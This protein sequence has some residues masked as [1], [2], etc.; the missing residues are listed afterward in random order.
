MNQ[1]NM[2]ARAGR[3]VLFVLIAAAALAAGLG[4]GGPSIASDYP[5][6][7][8]R[9]VVPF[10][11]GGPVDTLARMVGQKLSERWSHQV[12]VENIA[13]ANGIIGS[14]AVAKSAPDGHT[15]LLVPVGH[16]MNA[17][18]Y[19]RLPF[20][21]LNDFTAVVNVAAA[22][23]VLVMHPSVPIKT[24]AELVAYAKANPAKLTYA[25]AGVGS[26]NHLAGA[27][28]QSLAG[29]NIVHVPYKGSAPATNDLLGGHVSMIFNNMV[30]SIPY[31]ERGQL[32]G[33]AVT[34]PRR[35]PALP[36]LPT[37]AESG[38]AGFE[39]TGWYGIFGPARM[40]AEIVRKINAEVNQVINAADVRERM[41]TQG[42]DP[43]GG[44]AESF[45]AFVKAE[46]EKWRAVVKASGARAD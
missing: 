39:V 20:D 7:P 3:R 16:A 19:S 34:S 31:L 36:D 17:S 40:P 6:K 1:R 5:T 41:R 42:V 22:P 28:F 44:S 30:N 13:G 12:V 23:F 10:P 37:V 27:L 25:S 38:I 29:V 15:L 33:V 9:L 14:E 18:V 43:A 46:I 32:R 24:I 26:A 35:S 4:A 11:P 21:T 8:V 45:G 2:A